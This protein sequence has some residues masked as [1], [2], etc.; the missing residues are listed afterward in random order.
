MLFYKTDVHPNFNFKLFIS[1]ILLAP[2]IPTSILKIG[3]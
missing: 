3:F 2:K 1:T